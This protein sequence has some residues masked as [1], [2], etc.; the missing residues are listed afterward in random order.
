MDTKT[1]E[2]E[3]VFTPEELKQA[4]WD[5][6]DVMHR[7]LLQSKYVLLG[8][9]ARAA[10]DDT[11]L[12]KV[13]LEVGIF[14]RYMTPEV[15][16]LFTPEALR[17]VAVPITVQEI[18]DKQILLTFRGVPV[19]VTIIHRKYQMFENPDQVIYA[20]EDFQVANPFEKYWKARYIVQ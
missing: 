17:D 20:Y 4:L 16:S 9:T 3:R 14:K 8:D 12:T 7:A 2:V 10:K 11:F 1:S 18:N 5:W 6:D 19:K 15:V 13:P